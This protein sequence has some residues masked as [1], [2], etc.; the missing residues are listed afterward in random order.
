M[1]FATKK[2]IY[3]VFAVLFCFSLFL[4][5]KKPGKTELKDNHYKVIG[6]KKVGCIEYIDD[7]NPWDDNI[8]NPDHIVLYSNSNRWP[9]WSPFYKKYYGFANSKTGYISADIYVDKLAFGKDG[10]AWDYKG[11]F[12]DENG[13]IS[14]SVEEFMDG[15]SFSDN[16]RKF[17]LNLFLR[18]DSPFEFHEVENVSDKKFLRT[19]SSIYPDYWTP[20]HSRIGDLDACGL[21]RFP[22][23]GGYIYIDKSGKKVFDEKFYHATP[24]EE[25]GLAIVVKG[26]L[27]WGVIN[28]KGEYVI[29]PTNE[30]QEIEIIDSDKKIKAY[31][32]RN[33]YDFYD[34]D[35]NKLE[36]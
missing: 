1:K 30:Y 8:I 17:F 21:I 18:G 5:T 4:F 29:E 6:D 12:I 27:E 14:I 10:L 16:P 24:F 11:H 19:F 7:E 23:D 25:C 26:S 35:G 22:Y 33:E 36:Q 34:F 31:K 9:K 20:L 13:N 28:I 15:Y 2:I 32:G 3:L